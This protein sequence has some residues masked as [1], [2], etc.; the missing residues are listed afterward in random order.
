MR[1]HYCLATNQNCTSGLQSHRGVG[2]GGCGG[3]VR[4]KQNDNEGSERGEYGRRGESQPGEQAL[5][6][7][8]GCGWG[9]EGVEPLPYV[10]MSKAELLMGLIMD[11]TIRGTRRR[12]VA[13]GGG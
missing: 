9:Q 5:G 6:G 2:G 13:V 3:P 12:R 11:D 1:G 4:Q 10:W 7:G 8:T